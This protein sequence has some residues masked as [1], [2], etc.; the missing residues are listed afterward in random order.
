MIPW[1]SPIDGARS[2]GDRVVVGVPAPVTG[3]LPVRDAA[4][5]AERVEPIGEPPRQVGRGVFTAR[6]GA[7]GNLNI[8]SNPYEEAN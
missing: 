7:V 3:D 6:I 4:I 2:S 5:S 1:D 8:E